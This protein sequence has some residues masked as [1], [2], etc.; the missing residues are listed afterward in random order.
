MNPKKKLKERS[1]SS[2]AN[3][4]TRPFLPTPTTL[5][6]TQIAALLA[7]KSSPNDV[8]KL[9]QSAFQLWEACN[10]ELLNYR[11]LCAIQDGNCEVRMTGVGGLDWGTP[12]SC[13]CSFDEALRRVMPKK[14]TRGDRYNLF[15]LFVRYLIAAA[16]KTK[17]H[18]KKGSGLQHNTL[19]EKRMLDEIE[20]L[21]KKFKH[22]GFKNFDEYV[23]WLKPFCDWLSIHEAQQMSAQRSI[24]AKAKWDK[25]RGTKAENQSR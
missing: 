21:F 4:A 24:A 19:S 12:K 10:Q 11:I 1:D 7:G 17:P 20:F 3:A 6:L 8:S 2:G 25:Q 9:A 22:G 5:E 14:R 16:N 18:N 15:R 13:P 23:F